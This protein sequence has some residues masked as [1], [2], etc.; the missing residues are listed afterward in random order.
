MLHNHVRA[1]AGAFVVAVHHSPK[2]DAGFD[3]CAKS[4]LHNRVRNTKPAFNLTSTFLVCDDDGRGNQSLVLLSRCIADCA[5]KHHMSKYYNL[6]TG[7]KAG[8]ASEA[9]SGRS[10]GAIPGVP[11][12]TLRH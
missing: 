3:A 11:E 12:S 1:Q 7:S 2:H 9:A 8:L 6:S 5:S 10:F 4:P